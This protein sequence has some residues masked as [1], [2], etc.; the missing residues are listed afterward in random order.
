VLT[1][2]G[3]D[4][5]FVGYNIFREAKVRKFWSRDQASRSRSALLARLYPYLAQ[6]PPEFSRKF[7]GAGL[8]NPE[9]P[10]FSHRP[11]W[12]NTAPVA[13]FLAEGAAAGHPAGPA[14]ER[15]LNSLPGDFSSWGTVARAQ[16]VE[17]STFLS[18]YL[19]SSQGDRMLMANSVEG[20]FPYLDHELVEYAAGIPASVKLQ[21]LREKALLKDSVTDLVPP[22]ILAR[23]KYPFRAPGNTCFTSPQGAAMVEE[24]MLADGEGWDLWQR[25]KVA[26]LVRKWQ[27]GRL[28]SSRDDQSFVAV[29]SARIL[30]V[31]FG[32]DFE[33]KVAALALEPGQLVWRN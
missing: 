20:R 10:F 19:L 15:L 24:F 31:D 13:N 2:E 12:A 26:A 33:Q 23:P 11:R 5:I 4:E 18:G 9:D 30:Q 21:S 29:L 22:K 17:M 6:S 14:E 25:D 28:L 32:R 7:Y 8:D 16:Y 3:A 27:A 1:G